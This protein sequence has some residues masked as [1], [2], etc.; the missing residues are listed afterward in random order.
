MSIIKFTGGYREVEI[1]VPIPNTE[2]KRFISD[3]TG[4]FLRESRSL[5]V[6]YFISFYFFFYFVSFNGSNDDPSLKILISLF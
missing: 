6:F 1:P 2:V 5:P 3:G 4:V